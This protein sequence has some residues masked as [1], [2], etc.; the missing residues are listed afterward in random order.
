MQKTDDRVTDAKL[1]EIHQ[2]LLV[3]L[4]DEGLRAWYPSDVALLMREVLAQR[5]IIGDALRVARQNPALDEDTNDLVTAVSRI[6]EKWDGVKNGVW[7][8]AEV[9]RLRE[10]LAGAEA[11]LA[12]YSTVIASQQAHVSQLEAQ[13]ADLQARI[14]DT[15]SD[16]KAAAMQREGEHAKRAAKAE[17]LVAQAVAALR[18]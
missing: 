10:S 6:G 14:V 5:K 2:R 16:A 13:V 9:K 1:Q 15:I 7:A 3:P 4:N 8:K 12:Q 11:D 18:D 17:A